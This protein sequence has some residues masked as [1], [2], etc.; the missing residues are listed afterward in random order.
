[1]RD[2]RLRLPADGMP[3]ASVRT[4]HMSTTLAADYQTS[5]QQRAASGTGSSA[6]YVASFRSWRWHAPL[7]TRKRTGAG[8]LPH[9][10]KPLPFGACHTACSAGTWLALS[11][12][13]KA[14]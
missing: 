9:Y 12:I 1:M 11:P 10:G 13:L 6:A 2:G 8:R 5:A 14:P 3:S 4:L 7:G